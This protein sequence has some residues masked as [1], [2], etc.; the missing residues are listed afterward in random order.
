[1]SNSF[2]LTTSRDDVNET[3]ALLMNEDTRD[4]GEGGCDPSAQAS[5]TMVRY[6]A[7]HSVC[8]FNTPWRPSF[9][10][11]FFCL[12]RRLI[13]N[14]TCCPT[15]LLV[16]SGSWFT[17]LGAVF[18]DKVV[19][20]RLSDFIWV[21]TSASLNEAQCR[22][23]AHILYSL[24]QNIVKLRD[25]YL[26]VQVG[27]IDRPLLSR[28]FPSINAYRD[29]STKKIVHFTYL[30]PLENNAACVIFLAQTNE[31]PPKPIVVKFVERYGEAA[32]RLLGAQG[33]APRLFYF[34]QV[35]VNQGD[36]AYGHLRMVVME[37]IDGN[38]KPE[39]INLGNIP[40]TGSKTTGL[41]PRARLRVWGPPGR[42]YYDY[43]KP[44][45]EAD[46]L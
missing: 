5:L 41:S 1:L 2:I 33:T 7:Q 13:R 10:H 42:E 45:G 30:Q 6:W 44:R 11:F 32:H 46:R 38:T 43:K 26:A 15:F 40:I 23:I 31:R 28:Y 25:Y 3:V 22:R 8:A 24:R 12:Q 34:G 16:T 36:P 14:N 9:T 35:G 17:I 19:V 29:D 37:Y 27:P 4:I 20:Q 39:A 18:T 21:G